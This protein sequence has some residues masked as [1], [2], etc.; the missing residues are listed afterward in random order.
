[1]SGWMWLDVKVSFV[2]VDFR[3]RVQLRMPH[4][5]A[6]KI[7]ALRPA[8]E[9]LIFSMTAHPDNIMSPSP[10]DE[11]LLNIIREL[12]SPRAGFFGS[13]EEDSRGQGWVV[14]MFGTKMKSWVH[15]NM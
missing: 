9:A 8:I 14:F 13:P 4:T 2:L 11:A 15:K 10:Q 3:D 7:V 5:S 6:A 12:S 1:M